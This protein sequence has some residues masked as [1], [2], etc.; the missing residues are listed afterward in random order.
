LGSKQVEIPFNSNPT[1]FLNPMTPP[2]KKHC[3]ER[4]AES[5]AHRAIRLG[6]INIAIYLTPLEARVIRALAPRSEVVD[7]IACT[8]EE[9]FRTRKTQV[10]HV[11]FTVR[12]FLRGSKRVFRR[13]ARR[14]VDFDFVSLL[15]FLFRKQGFYPATDILHRAAAKGATD[16]V[17]FLLSLHNTQ[18]PYVLEQAALFG[19]ITHFE[20]VRCSGSF[21]ITP[22]CVGQA[23][24]SCRFELVLHLFT[25]FRLTDSETMAHAAIAA[26]EDAPLE[27]VRFLLGRRVPF[28]A[29][30]L[31]IAALRGRTRVL[32]LLLKAG[33]VPDRDAITPALLQGRAD[34]IEVFL[35]HS[36]AINEAFAPAALVGG[37]PAIVKLFLDYGVKFSPGLRERFSHFFE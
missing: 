26:A 12:K 3:S 20:R 29:S 30:C 4:R 16:C 7:V 36:S 37:H 22:R 17:R 34:I 11:N 21:A 19:S 24:R 15:Q 28:D 6:F 14:A 10:F 2:L 27:T 25:N 31:T 8:L 13:L 5:L 32:K 23:V 9:A 33:I 35:N 1:N 18:D